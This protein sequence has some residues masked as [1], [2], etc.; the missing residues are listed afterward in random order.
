MSDNEGNIFVA[1]YVFPGERWVEP[2]VTSVTKLSPDG[3]EIWTSNVNHGPYT[4]VYD[5][6]ID[7]SGNLY[8][9]GNASN[10]AATN[11]DKVDRLIW[12]SKI[13]SDTGEVEWT[14]TKESRDPLSE[15]TDMERFANAGWG[16]AVDSKNH[17]YLTGG[18]IFRSG[19]NKRDSLIY[20]AA[21]SGE[22]AL[23]WEERNGA[24][25]ISTDVAVDACDNIY[26]IGENFSGSG[27]D[28]VSVWRMGK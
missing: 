26:V 14:K 16:L 28:P 20:L 17:V 23:M 19:G 5:L 4:E 9:T 21:Y 13:S 24:A 2:P 7:R 8:A 25:E 1:G 22:G 10:N 11:P 15:E 18:E 6:A 12:L 27:E 3:E